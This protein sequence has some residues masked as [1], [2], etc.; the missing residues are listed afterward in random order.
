[1]TRTFKF[2]KVLSD[3]GPPFTTCKM[4]DQ[5]TKRDHETRPRKSMDLPPTVGQKIKK[6]EVGNVQEN[7]QPE[8]D[9]HFKNRGGKN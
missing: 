1:M 4:Y 2:L 9:S 6:V 3:I 5:R 7:A 8:K